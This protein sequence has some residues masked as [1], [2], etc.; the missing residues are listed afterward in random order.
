MRI[1]LQKNFVYKINIF[2]SYE[3]PWEGTKY[4]KDQTDLENDKKN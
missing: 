4:I 3:S 1:F 2:N